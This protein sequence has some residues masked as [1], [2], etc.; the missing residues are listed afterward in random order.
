MALPPEEARQLLIQSDAP[1]TSSEEP[2]LSSLPVPTLGLWALTATWAAPELPRPGSVWSHTLLLNEHAL[3][4]LQRGSSLLH[5]FRRPSGPEDFGLYRHT[6]QLQD[7]IQPPA[8][9][10]PDNALAAVALAFY[11]WPAERVAVITE[12][13]RA[14]ERA[15]MMLW[16]QQWPALRARAS[17]ASRGRVGPSTTAAIQVAERPGRAHEPDL[18]TLRPA[19]GELPSPPWVWPL[20]DDAREPGALRAFLHEFGD[21]T[22]AG[23]RD[24]PALVRLYGA[25]SRRPPTSAA[26][27]ELTSLYPKKR[28]MVRL[29]SE[30]LSEFGSAWRNASEPEKVL[31][32]LENHQA[33]SWQKLDLP[34]RIVRLAATDNLLFED[35]LL[36]AWRSKDAK[37]ADAVIDAVA[38]S[39]VLDS[40]LVR[41]VAEL[42]PEL[43]ARLAA[44]DP[45][46]LYDEQL[47]KPAARSGESLLDALARELTSGADQ[48]LAGALVDAGGDRL[49]GYARKLGLVSPNGVAIALAEHGATAQSL[50]RYERLLGDDL[51]DVVATAVERTNAWGP[52]MLAAA[53]SSPR[54][55]EVIAAAGPQLRSHLWDVDEPL[56]TTVATRLLAQK[57]SRRRT[58]ALKD[59]F[60][61]VHGALVDQRV[62]PEL[63]RSLDTVLPEEDGLDLAERLRVLI[64]EVIKRQRW[65]ATQIETA[66]RGA[67]PKAKKLADLFP[68]KSRE[69][70]AVTDALK[71][72]NLGGDE[73]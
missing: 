11:G 28:D 30:A 15:L 54:A 46:A 71:N 67:G 49:V 31:A 32:A 43:A 50:T 20:I 26:I 62:G 72:A 13:L 55:G 52:V 53:S 61:I 51:D 9:P 4:G 65:D 2:V 12:D 70:K 48:R 64:S 18:I 41:S 38:H 24:V 22:P 10:T 6:L 17:F 7:P 25:L 3:A 42:E 35:A 63:S 73:K 23:Y 60:G 33:I 56:R 1:A 44:R 19:Q 59:A 69:R 68:K 5:A 29:K 45:A 40:Q 58:A 37:L 39:G 27:R 36:A 34:A 66:L 57:D 47:W 16:S 14:G 8:A 21:E